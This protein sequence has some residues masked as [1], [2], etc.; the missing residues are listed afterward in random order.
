MLA[1]D[2]HVHVDAVLLVAHHLICH[3]A[4]VILG[5][6]TLQLVACD[7]VLYTAGIVHPL[8]V[9]QAVAQFPLNVAV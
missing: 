2:A 8:L 1:H 7:H 4:L 6:F 5:A 9:Y 3:P